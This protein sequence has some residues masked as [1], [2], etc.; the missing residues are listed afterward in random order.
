MTGAQNWPWRNETSVSL[1]TG[2]ELGWGRDREFT[3][4]RSVE[5]MLDRRR[6]ALMWEQLMTVSS[7]F[8]PTSMVGGLRLSEGTEPVTGSDRLVCP[9]L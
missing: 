8:V 2:N 7:S 6:N 9:S 1:S 5:L 3:T 4:A